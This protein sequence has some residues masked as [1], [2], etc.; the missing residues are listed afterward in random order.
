MPRLILDCDGLDVIIPAS[1]THSIFHPRMSHGSVAEF[2]KPSPMS[3]TASVAHP[4]MVGGLFMVIE[5]RRAD[6]IMRVVKLWR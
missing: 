1:E 4:L 3:F 5:R 6:S 2:K